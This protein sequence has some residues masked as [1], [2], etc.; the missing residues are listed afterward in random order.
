MDKPS[1]NWWRISSY[2]FHP[3]S[4]KLGYHGNAENIMGIFMA[5]FN[6]PEDIHPKFVFGRSFY[7]WR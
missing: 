4:N 3:Q 6:S 2:F 7:E 1:T 5:L